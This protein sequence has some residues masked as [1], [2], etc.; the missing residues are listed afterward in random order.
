[1]LEAWEGNTKKKPLPFGRLLLVV[2]RSEP[3]RY[4]YLKH[5]FGDGLEV[6]LDRRAEMR[7][8][9][10]EPAAEKRR[11]E[12]RRSHDISEDLKLTGWALVRR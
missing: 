5:V 11:R 4:V 2:S 7:R 12:D 9:S 10:T 3:T 6:I 8:R 1:M